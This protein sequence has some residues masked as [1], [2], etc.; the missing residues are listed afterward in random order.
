MVSSA[1]HN[2]QL[3]EVGKNCLLL[4]H[5]E[6]SNIKK[7]LYFMVIGKNKCNIK[8][9]YNQSLCRRFQNNKMVIMFFQLPNNKMRRK[10]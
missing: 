10:L 4:D 7:T 5:L 2:W 9:L 1:R 6:K 3:Y 8:K